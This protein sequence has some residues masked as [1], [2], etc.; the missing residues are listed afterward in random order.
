MYDALQVAC[1]FVHAQQL[2]VVGRCW[3]DWDGDTCKGTPPPC[4]VLTPVQWHHQLLRLETG[5]SILGL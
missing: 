5:A 4:S 1:V 2:Y 3:F